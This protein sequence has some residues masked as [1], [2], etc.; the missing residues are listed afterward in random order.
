MCMGGDRN[1][2]L[3]A[4]MGEIGTLAHRSAVHAS[5]KSICTEISA[6]PV[7]PNNQRTIQILDPSLWKGEI[8]SRTAYAKVPRSVDAESTLR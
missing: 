6:P 3:S 7:T 1:V 4:L 5:R 2:V 8:P